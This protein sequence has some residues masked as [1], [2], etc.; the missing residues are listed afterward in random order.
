M[1]RITLGEGDAGASPEAV[2]ALHSILVEGLAVTLKRDRRG[3]GAPE[4][5]IL[6]IVSARIARF[7]A[8]ERAIGVEDAPLA[9]EQ[10]VE[11][12]VLARS[13]PGLRFWLEIVQE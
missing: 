7:R 10:L 4:Q 6:V 13:H 5:D 1:A 12:R 8:T 2:D 3:L 9:V 11:R